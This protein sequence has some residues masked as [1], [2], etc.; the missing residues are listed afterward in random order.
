[1][2]APL[3]STRLRKVLIW[4][5]GA[6]IGLLALL[7]AGVVIALQ[8]IDTPRVRA[9]LAEKLSTLLNGQVSW[10]E[11]DIRLLP[12]PHGVVRGAH[13]AI[14]NVVTVDV[15]TADVKISLLPLFKGNAEVQ[16]IT[17]ERP[18]VEVWIAPSA[19]GRKKREAPAQPAIPLALYRSAMRGVLDAAAR[20]APATTV[21]IEDGR[22]AWHL[23]GLPLEVSRLN[24]R[25]VTDGNGVA[26]DASAT[27]THW[28]RVAIEGRV[29][30]ADLSARVRV[31]GT[32]LKVQRALEGLLPSMRETLA[33]SSVGAKVEARTDGHTDIEIGLGLDLHKAAIQLGAKQLDIGQVR[34]AGSIKL[35]EADVAVVLQQ[36]KLGELAPAAN[37]GLVLA[38]PT[39]APKLDIAIGEL[40]LARLRDATLTLVGDRPAVKEY[41]ARI[42]GGRLRDVR[43]S[44]Q[45]ESFGQ[46]FALPRLHATAQLADAS[47]R[48]PQLEREATDIAARAELVSG[49]LKVDD[50]SARLGASQL[51]RAGVNIV[52]L[53]PMRMERTRGQAS[54]V[55]N[56]L[57]PGLRAREPF[58]RL[59][60]SV[61]TLTGVAA[62]NVRNVALRFGKP[63]QLAYDLSVTPQ[64]VRIESDKLAEA[65][66]V[67]G[68]AVRVTPAS[69][70]ADRVG[71]D[72]LDS[73][74]TVSGEVRDFQ[75]G[76]PRVTARVADG[77]VGR[78]LV[79]WI[80]L[81][82]AL[83]ERLKPATPLRFTAPRLEW[84]TAGLDVA[85][86]AN[87]KAGPSLSVDLSQ[88]GKTFTLRRAT[89]KDRDSDASISLAMHD[90]LLEVGFAGV[91]AARSV[92]PLFG[93]PAEGYPGTVKGDLQATLDLTRPGRSAARG[94]LAGEHVD[95]RELTGTPLQLERFDLQGAGNAL[96]IRELTLDWAQQKATIRGTIA[97]E[98]NAL[99]TNLEIDSP[100]IVIDA[101][102]ATPAAKAADAPAEK[103]SKPRRSLG[104]WSLPLKGTVSL[105][106]DFVAYRGYRVQG[107]RAVATLERET[108]AISVAE[109]SL[110]GIAFP[111]SFRVTPKDFD[112]SANITVK[113]Q[114]LEEV[115]KC[116]GGNNVVISGN[117]DMTSVLTSKG[118]TQRF[119][120]SLAENLAG[121]V[122]VATRDGQIR[123]MALL[124]NILSLK[125][126]RDV[127]KGDVGFGAK[128]FDYRSIAVGAKIANRELTIE[129]AALDSPALGLAAAGTIN[130]TN[131]DS[132]LTVLVAPFGTLDRIVRKIPVLGYVI[133]GAFT[134]IPVGVSGDIRDPLVAPLGPRAV[135]SEVL[136]V[137]E[138]TFKLP[139]RLVE[140]LTTKPSE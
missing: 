33:L 111:L 94:T 80:W 124:G 18:N 92:A 41:V 133:G 114:S 96:Q 81:R 54:I 102:R 34:L 5:L 48:V 110:C 29:E 63:R 137:F 17:V 11:L 52:F 130:L 138:R 30:S 68:G 86:E 20:F 4:S 70:S 79:D 131:Y 118:P 82:T 66:S 85:A 71:I 76:K 49:V 100:G 23:P 98:A 57:L 97:R 140:P 74:A 107:I 84:S 108:M 93:H 126:V 89:I 127:V 60:R 6:A 78:K 9:Q 88:R 128:G 121:S 72:V 35:I 69:I 105:R 95:L 36:I 120:E 125:S 50:V 99:G 47:M 90:S 55:L 116:L 77:V 64:H 8:L 139:G 73:R 75:G 113:D 53:K 7:A 44:T 46:L 56:D 12:R 65:P 101:L 1:M 10:E 26:V 27:G 115:V 67:H 62:A 122:T 15:A 134:S 123:K 136:G 19:A 39:R 129:Q 2:A 59:L 25:L 106:T 51:R 83:P 132:R 37:A 40:D 38:G 16:A 42:H 103:E 21:A 119:G 24:L 22:V 112:A 135:G 109:A 14:P 104:L 43:F 13:V 91:L 61:P 58:D 87:V 117:F 45:A 31:E 3:M 32:G 28:D